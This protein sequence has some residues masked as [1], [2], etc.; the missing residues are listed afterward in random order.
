MGFLRRT[1]F[2]I[3]YY[4]NP[5]WDSGISPPELMAFIG[6]EKPGRALD[7]GCG[8]GTNIVTLSRQGW[9]VTGIDFSPRAISLARRKLKLAEVNADLLIGDVT[10]LDGVDGAFD[11][12]LDLGCF[13]GLNDHDQEKYLMQLDRVCSSSCKWLL[14]GFIRPSPDSPGPGFTP[15]SISRIEEYFDQLSVQSGMDITGRRSSYLLFKKKTI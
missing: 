7:L 12:I 4:F 1:V 11:F 14:Y 6:N 5:P 9:Q 2:N 3:W 8:T 10:R 13:H 15:K